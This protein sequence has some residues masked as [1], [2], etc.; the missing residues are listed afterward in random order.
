MEIQRNQSFI[1]DIN[2]YCQVNSVP[3]KITTLSAKSLFPLLDIYKAG[4]NV[5][6]QNG[7]EDIVNGLLSSFGRSIF[8][9][10]EGTMEGKS[11]FDKSKN[12]EE[13][14]V[15]RIDTSNRF[16]ETKMLIELIISIS[17]A[18]KEMGNINYSNNN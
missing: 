1:N 17:L 12:P 8:G 4:A 11:E 13:I 5:L 7:A 9:N 2:S 6:N 10:E 16:C 3:L 14:C 15:D 18:C